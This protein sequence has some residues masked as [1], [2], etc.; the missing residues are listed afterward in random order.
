MHARVYGG[1]W[2]EEW[3]PL[4]EG[5]DKFVNKSFSTAYETEA[6]KDTK[7]TD[8]HEPEEE[9]QYEEEPP[10]HITEPQV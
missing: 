7:G 1:P 8:M 4:D 3:R 9:V 10:A 2:Q 5:L 6:H